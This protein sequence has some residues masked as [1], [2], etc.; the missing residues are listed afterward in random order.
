MSWI[1]FAIVVL[2]YCLGLDRYIP[3]H[4]FA[5]PLPFG[6]A[7]AVVPYSGYLRQFLWT[8]GIWL[9]LYGILRLLD[10]YLDLLKRAGLRQ[11]MLYATRPVAVLAFARVLA[12]VTLIVI[13][14]KLVLDST[15]GKIIGT[16]LKRLFGL[17]ESPAA[18]GTESALS[19]LMKNIG[20]G[21]LTQWLT[22]PLG[23]LSSLFPFLGSYYRPSVPPPFVP[24]RI[25]ILCILTL[26]AAYAFRRERQWQYQEDLQEQQ[27]S[28]KH[29]PGEIVVPSADR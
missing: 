28:R 21:E 1:S 29:R 22:D 18:A 17:V 12:V 19:Q 26:I 11:R 3:H 24:W 27:R 10:R 25:A 7:K 15:I 5:I 4:P 13:A 20:G 8:L 23:S 16:L 2:G 9:V 14:V 6:W